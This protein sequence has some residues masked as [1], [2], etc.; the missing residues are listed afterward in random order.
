MTQFCGFGAYRIF[1]HNIVRSDRYG[2][3]GI[4]RGRS[5]GR[6]S[7]NFYNFRFKDGG[8]YRPRFL[9]NKTTRSALSKFTSEGLFA[10]AVFERKVHPGAIRCHF[11]VFHFH[12]KLFNLRNPQVA[13]GL[14]G[15]FDRIFR[16]FFPGSIA[17]SHQ[18]NNFVDTLS[19]FCL[20]SCAPGY[21]RNWGSNSGSG[22]LL[23]FRPLPPSGSD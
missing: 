20:L 2:K 21:Q 15:S 14:A 12:V 11:A 16:S 13:K 23:I 18:L 8:K 5:I 4:R 1:A 10:T 19:H 6:L 22:W 9:P 17:A 7:I 3:M